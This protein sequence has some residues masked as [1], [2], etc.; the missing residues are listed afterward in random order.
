M[1]RV[2]ILMADD[3]MDDTMLVGAAFKAAGIKNDFRTVENGK[4]LLDYLRR[5]GSYADSSLSPRPDLILLDLNMPLLHGKDAL[6]EIKTSDDLK[7]I[8]VVVLTTTT[9]EKNISE[10]YFLGASAYI[11]KPVGFDELTDAARAI[12]RFWFQLAQLPANNR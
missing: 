8:P 7:S 4:D 12:G 9:E 2:V 6:R 10:C 11:V 5:E 1:K 3:D